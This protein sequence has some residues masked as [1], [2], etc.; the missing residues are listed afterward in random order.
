MYG[1]RIISQHRSFGLS[2][3]ITEF[4][5]LPPIFCDFSFSLQNN[6]QNQ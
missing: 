1:Q 3:F 6:A 4:V 2:Y 5:K